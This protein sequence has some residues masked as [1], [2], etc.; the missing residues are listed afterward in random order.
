MQ[1]SRPE[2]I[3]IRPVTLIQTLSPTSTVGDIREE[4]LHRLIQMNLG[5]QLQADVQSKLSDGSFLVKIADTTA[6]MNLPVSTNVGDKL[7]L[8]LIGKEPRPTFLMNANPATPE[9]AS[10]TTSLS[11]TAKMIDSLLQHLPGNNQLTPIVS[12]TPI[13]PQANLP[14]PELANALRD[15]ISK[16]GLFY[17]SHLNEWVNGSAKPMPATPTDASNIQYIQRTLEDIK[18]EPQARQNSQITAAMGVSPSQPV[19]DTSNQSITQLVNQ[20]LQTLEQQRVI[21]QGEVWPGL[22]M[23]WEVAED[24][25]NDNVAPDQRSWHSQVRFEMSQL[26]T[27]TANLNLTGG[28]LSLQIHADTALIAQK[29]QSEGKRLDDALAAAGIPLDRLQV[30]IHE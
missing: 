26:G 5:Q 2:P 20:Q 25:Q 22:P 1:F 18:Q 24:P 23:E 10:S 14:T 12:S 13:S 7:A 27:I 9:A 4:A 11:N 29:L 28:R 21:W 19:L 8:T 17:E 30:K 6:R 3:G 16:S 15:A